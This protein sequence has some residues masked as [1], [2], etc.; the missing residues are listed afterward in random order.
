MTFDTALPDPDVA[1]AALGLRDGT[2]AF[3][4]PSHP[5]QRANMSLFLGQYD[6]ATGGGVTQGIK[7]DAGTPLSDGG[8][9][10]PAAY[11]ALF[12]SRDEAVG[13]L[14]ET[15]GDEAFEGCTGGYCSIVLSVIKR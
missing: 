11:S 2:V 7:W 8:A 4:N 3:S 15:Q 12:E 6:S 9:A 1:G 14:W 5:T 13:I 10:V